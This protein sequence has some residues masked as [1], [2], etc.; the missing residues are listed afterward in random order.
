MVFRDRTYTV[1]EFEAFVRQHPD[2]RFELI[3]GEINEKMP[4]QYHAKVAMLIALAIA[5]Y[6]SEH[7]IGHILPEARYGLPGDE[8]NTVIPDF[9]YVSNERGALVK[10]GAAPYMPDMAIEVQSPNQSAQLM[11]NKAIYYVE[12]GSRMVI[13]AYPTKRIVEV[14]TPIGRELLTMNDSIHGGDVL[15]GF[16]LPVQTIFPPEDS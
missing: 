12:H 6:L 7:P 14:L 13:V 2:R 4:T 10:R 15:P 8:D 16:E 1:A 5:H 3:N 11:L 9:S